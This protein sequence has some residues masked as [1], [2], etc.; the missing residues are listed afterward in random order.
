MV[1]LSLA[2]VGVKISKGINNKTG[3]EEITLHFPANLRVKVEGDH[4]TEAHSIIRNPSGDTDPRRN[5]YSNIIYDA[6][7]LDEHGRP[8][9][10][11]QLF[12]ATGRWV[13]DALGIYDD[14]GRLER[15]DNDLFLLEEIAPI[16][17][18]QDNHRK[19][20]CHENP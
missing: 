15:G 10:I 14:T 16:L 2:D 6:C 7:P 5:G 3:E 13:A 19:C 9:R 4:V 11:T 18:L 17:A 1:E 12:D 20:S 8:R